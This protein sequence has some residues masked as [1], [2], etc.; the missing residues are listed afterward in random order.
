LLSRQTFTE[1]KIQ[2]ES[3]KRTNRNPQM[4]DA[5]TRVSRARTRFP[6]N[7][8]SFCSRDIYAQA[9]LFAAAIFPQSEMYTP[10]PCVG[11]SEADG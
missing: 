4:N 2:I 1:L 3:L 5:L 7:S 9:F 10:S 8:G 6:I 11:S